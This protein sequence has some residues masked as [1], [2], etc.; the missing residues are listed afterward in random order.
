MR[1]LPT[2]LF[3]ALAFAA[4]AQ[5]TSISGTILSPTADSASVWRMRTEGRQQ[6]QEILATGPIGKDGRFS[7]R[8][9]LDSARA[10]V[11]SDGNEITHVYMLPGESLGL[12]LH[13]AY[14]D[15]T[16]RFTGDGAARNNM[17]ASLA[18]ADE[19]GMLSNSLYAHAQQADPAAIGHR[20][21]EHMKQMDGML[22]DLSRSFPEMSGLL[23][24]RKKQNASMAEWSKR[25][26]LGELQF[27]A[28][29][30][31]SVGKP[32][33][34]IAGVNLAG[35]TVR[36]SQFKGKTTVVDFWATWCGPCQM[37]MPS[38]AELE[39]QYGGQV[40]FVSISVWDDHTRWKART[41]EL[42]HKHSLFI[43]KEHLGQ[44]D[45]YAINSIPR[46]M[47][48]D[49][50]LKIITIDAPRPSSPDLVKLF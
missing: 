14:F 45:P 1:T 25:S 19:I 29:R 46:Y 42:G 23:A 38:W 34:D 18:V 16:L 49:K 30:R 3:A 44:L 20:V 21:D 7:L 47:V 13:T 6:V 48:I 22:D 10:L 32:L 4:T 2:M 12:T 33:K 27:A 37:E 17:L 8:F 24:D 35:D 9:A 31:E 28:L 15:E 40:N 39:K 26:I 43:D 50:D 5:N 41:A 11:F 36:L